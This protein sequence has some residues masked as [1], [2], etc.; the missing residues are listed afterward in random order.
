MDR[1]IALPPGFQLKLATKT[2]YAVYRICR[3]IGRGGSCIV[4]DASYTDNQGHN[5]LVR[6]NECYPYMEKIHRE[7]DGS[8]IADECDTQKFALAKERLTTAYER[9]HI[10]FSI[11]SLTNRVV[12]TSDIYA[13]GGTIYVV[14]VY[15]NGRTFSDF[16]GESLHDCVSL[17]LSAAKALKRIHDAGYLYLDLKPDNILTL[18]GSLDLVQL[19]DFD[20]MISAEELAAAILSNAPDMLRASYTKGYAPLEQQTG[21]LRHLGKHSDLYSLGAVLFHA[22]WKRTPTAFDCDPDAHFDYSTT[23]YSGKTY[24]DA[25]YP[26]LTLFFH[27][28]LSSYY[29]DRYQDAAEAIEQLNNVLK[30]SDEKAP[31]IRSTLIEKNT[32]FYGRAVEQSKLQALLH[33]P[34][35]KVFSLYG[36]GGIGKSALVRQYL[37]EHASEW[38]AILWLYD[39]GD[40]SATLTDD[41]QVMINTV[42]RMKG[43]GNEEYLTRKLNVISM[44]AKEQRILLVLD[45][46]ES[47]H[48][49]QLKLIQNIGWTIL[50]ISRECLPEGLYPAMQVRELNENELMMLFKHYAHCDEPDETDIFSIETI[51]SCI[52]NHT[53]LTELIARQISKSFLDLQEAETI[54]TDM[55]LENLPAE[56][57]DYVRDQSIF[58]GT[59]SKILD[60][61]VEIDRFTA[62]DQACMK[63]LSLFDAPG[64]EAHLFKELS[65]IQSLDFIHELAL[66]GWLKI[67]RNQFS[68]HPMMQE[69]VRT[70]PWSDTARK[71]AEGMMRTLYERIRPDHTRHDCGRQ[72]PADYN[73]FYRLLNLARQMATHFDLVTESSQHLLYRWLMDSPV[74]QDTP[75]LYKMLELL[76]NPQFLDDDSILC[77]Y[78]TAAYYRARLYG[79]DEAVDLLGSMKRYLVKHPSAYYLSAYHQAFATILINASRDLKKVL[80]HEDRAIEAARLSHHPGAKKQLAF[81]LLNKA[82]TL[83]SERMDQEQVQKLMGEAEPLMMQ[84]TASTDYERYQYACNAAMCFAMGGDYTH[85]EEQLKAADDIAFSFP[86]SD[87]SVA[88]HL[89]GEAA[90]IRLEMGQFDLAETVIVR[91]IKLC[92]KHPNELR[93][94]ET[95]FEACCFL[96]RIYAMNENFVKAEETYNEAERRLDETFFDVERPLC[97]KDVHEKA[98]AQRSNK[99]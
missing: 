76:N 2:G 88:E 3:E 65:G 54:F 6:I 33:Q 87:L 44:L 71:M 34:R 42:Q 26:A 80:W 70:W 21:K 64:I 58:H 68:L 73:G 62:Q 48:L 56:Q 23:V 72:F 41:L 28:T 49:E 4:Y 95:A 11:D 30:L 18:E 12:N 52:G 51:L 74:D 24:Q 20:S 16:Q 46:F 67:D 57:I 63:V 93:Y 5:K 84:Y 29:A 55:G 22:L 10:L 82:R 59:L 8:L 92:D 43:E 19:F 61:L 47:G 32:A 1:R 81:C 15:L 89:I 99:N 27:K 90:P 40:L 69:Y 38:D 83:M 85:A 45:N 78:E 91:A 60:R 39:Q 75:V 53:L 98:M 79:T 97:P 77:L 25:L 17:V 86:D 37:S 36:M 50:L 9:N 35:E 94:Q 14:S 66:S 7:A 31:W 96:A 13:A